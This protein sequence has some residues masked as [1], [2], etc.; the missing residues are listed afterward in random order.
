MGAAHCKQATQP[1]IMC[2][3]HLCSALLLE[4]REDAALVVVV[5]AHVVQQAARQ[6]LAVE[7]AEEVLVADVR[8]QLDDL[9]QS[10]ING[11][12]TVAEA[13]QGDEACQQG[14]SVGMMPGCMAASAQTGH[15]VCCAVH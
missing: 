9:V 4:A 3:P 2:R 5:G 1:S 10:V 15:S 6:L 7:L 12:V 8:Q 14:V 13:E 11:L